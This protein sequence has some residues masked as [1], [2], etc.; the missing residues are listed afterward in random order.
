MRTDS[1]MHGTGKCCV[2]CVRQNT[3]VKSMA[4]L[5]Q[6][7]HNQPLGGT[8]YSALLQLGTATCHD[9]GLLCLLFMLTIN[10]ADVAITLKQRLDAG[11]LD[12]MAEHAMRDTQTARNELHKKQQAGS[13]MMHKT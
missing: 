12:V 11:M 3:G 7:K 9:Q 13:R 5:D 10:N 2:E 8:V 4:R 1:Q 6:G